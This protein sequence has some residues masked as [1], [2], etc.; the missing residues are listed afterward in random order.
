MEKAVNRIGEGRRENAVRDSVPRKTQNC[1]GSG[2]ALKGFRRYEHLDPALFR[3][4][5]T[6]IEVKIVPPKSRS[7]N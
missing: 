4:L 7:D 6:T 2:K 1:V 5:G 3:F